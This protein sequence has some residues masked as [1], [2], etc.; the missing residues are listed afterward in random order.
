MSSGFTKWSNNDSSNLNIRAIRFGFK[1]PILEVELNEL[2]DLSY[3][4]LINS[5]RVDNKPSTY[6]ASAGSSV[7]WETNV[8]STNTLAQLVLTSTSTDDVLKFVFG[9]GVEFFV[10]PSVVGRE[11]LTSVSLPNGASVGAYYTLVMKAK[12]K[13]VSPDPSD[14]DYDSDVDYAIDSRTPS[15]IT[16]KRVIIDTEFNGVY[17]DLINESTYEE[18]VSEIALQRVDNLDDD[19]EVMCILGS[20][21]KTE[22]G[23]ELR[24]ELQREVVGIEEP[25]YQLLSDGIDTY[26]TYSVTPLLSEG[27]CEVRLDFPVKSIKYGYFAIMIDGERVTDAMPINHPLRTS[28]HILENERLTIALYD[29]RDIVVDEAM[30]GDYTGQSWEDLLNQKWFEVDDYT[31]PTLQMYFKEV[32]KLGDV[33]FGSLIIK[34]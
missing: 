10:R 8:G 1:K 6:R 12:L 16:T 23:W 18:L 29:L 31:E 26:G 28:Q 9:G 30:W 20:W 4:A 13:T 33:A 27:T 7:V 14:S 34:K 17:T 2:Q 15:L 25:K 24:H 3:M 5:N 19:T 32:S 22:N 21:K 11:I